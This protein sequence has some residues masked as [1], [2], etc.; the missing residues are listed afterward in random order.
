MISIKIDDGQIQKFFKD[1]PK[2]ARWAMKE[3]L[4]M[5]GG[6]VRK[7]LKEYV[8]TQTAGMVPLHPVTVK[9]RTGGAAPLH[10]ISK[11]VSFKYGMRAGIQQV[12]IGWIGSQGKTSIIKKL[13]Y[14]KRFRASDKIRA[15]FHRRGVHL[16]KSTK[17]LAVPARP[18]LDAFWSKKSSEIPAYVEK[19]FF[20]KFN[21]RI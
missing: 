20:E 13:F 3:A 7:G 17:M 8:E 14:G 16:K 10:N 1:S 2:K 11:W 21:S 4:S 9:G 19:R 18:A 5:V 12:Q 6:H 15:L